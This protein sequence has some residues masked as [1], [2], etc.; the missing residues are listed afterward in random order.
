[1]PCTCSVRATARPRWQPKKGGKK[2]P[3]PK[4][5]VELHF[6]WRLELSHGRR[7]IA[8]A[9]S[10]SHQKL[11][12]RK[13]PRRFLSISL[14]YPASPILSLNPCLRVSE[15]RV[16]DLRKRFAQLQGELTAANADL[17]GLKESKEMAEQELRGAQVQLSMIDASIQAQEVPLLT[18]EVV[19]WSF[20]SRSNRRCFLAGQD[21]SAAGGDTE[22]TF[23][24]GCTQGRSQT[25]SLMNLSWFIQTLT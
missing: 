25:H 8:E 18:F 19:R 4:S 5:P 13:I 2:S 20:I 1:M 3:I 21:R 23:Q 9:T 6:A 14:R 16:S 24:C 15:H 12:L 11:R 10:R 22:V 7:W 17:E